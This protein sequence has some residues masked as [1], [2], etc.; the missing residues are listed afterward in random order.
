MRFELIPVFMLSIQIASTG[1][2]KTTHLQR[3]DTGSPTICHHYSA[4]SSRLHGTPAKLT[5]I[6][7]LLTIKTHALL[8]SPDCM[9]TEKY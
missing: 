4:I 8:Q 9:C 7:E 2:S 1:P 3:Q 6:W 5:H